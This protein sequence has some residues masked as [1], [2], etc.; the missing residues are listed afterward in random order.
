MTLHQSPHVGPQV[1]FVKWR[2]V[3]RRMRMETKAADVVGEVWLAMRN[4]CWDLINVFVTI[5]GNSVRAV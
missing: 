3:A 5:I 1:A 2:D 4:S